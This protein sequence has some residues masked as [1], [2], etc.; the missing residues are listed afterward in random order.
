MAGVDTG[1][2]Q[3]SFV[4]GNCITVTID[5]GMNNKRSRTQR[6]RTKVKI[7]NCKER[8]RAQGQWRSEG[9]FKGRP[10]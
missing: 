10:K 3:L 5:D 2:G 8:L 9:G 7:D 4:P 6:T 1:G